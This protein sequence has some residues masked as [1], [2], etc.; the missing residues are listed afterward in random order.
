MGSVGAGHPVSRSTR[1]AAVVVLSVAAVVGCSGGTPAPEDPASGTSVAPTTSEAMRPTVDTQ[2]FQFSADTSRSGRSEPLRAESTGRPPV[3]VE[4]FLDVGGGGVALTYADDA[5][6][7]GSL[8]LSFDLSR[9]SRFANVGESVPA[10][11][12]LSEGDAQVEV[13]ESTWDASS[14]TLTATTDHLSK[15][16][17]ALLDPKAVTD[18]VSGA[19][20]GFLQQAS[21]RPDC[22]GRTAEVGSTTYSLDPPFTAEHWLCLRENAGA[23]SIDVISNSPNGWTVQSTPAFSAHQP[24]VDRSLT[25]LIDLAAFETVFANAYG[26]GSYVAPEGSTTLDYA[27]DL[28]PQR[29]TLQLDPGMSLLRSL[30]LGVQA[31]YPSIPF[32]AVNDAA[33]C[34]KILD[35]AREAMEPTGVGAGNFHREVSDCLSLSLESGE[36]TTKEARFDASR[37][38][39]MT[40]VPDALTTLAA[41]VRGAVAPFLGQGTYT[42]NVRTSQNAAP[43]AASNATVNLSTKVTD[44]GWGV[45]LGPNHFRVSDLM[46]RDGRFFADTNYEW[47][48]N[49]PDGSD[50]GY[51]QGHVQILGPSGVEVA[52]YD[53]TGFDQCR[54]G[55]T[56][57]T[58]TRIFDAGTYTVN[59]EI[60]MEK[61][62]T[63]RA[64]QQFVVDQ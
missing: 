28:P 53:Q 35:A 64:S 30:F 16:W 20:L 39:I 11:V 46:K 1:I 45:E 10:V 6:P 31:L 26:D 62:P 8:G 4:D 19:A 15:F 7:D 47:T 58:S 21:P 42:V 49:R 29:L 33:A 5:Q 43:G 41:N 24:V 22:V 50:L 38:S 32:G 63:L 51:C 2:T 59:L 25:G 55:G 12:A 37:L 52:R 61:G 23:V 14:R 17:P 27:P 48:I 54:G 9:D 60:L 40:M 3:Q 18:R 36:A 13:L 56:W 57:G 34:T 44:N